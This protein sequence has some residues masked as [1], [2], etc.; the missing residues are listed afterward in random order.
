MK[1]TTLKFIESAMYKD[2][3]SAGVILKDAKTKA[4]VTKLAMV[5][6]DSVDISELLPAAVMAG[7]LAR[8]RKE[9]EPSKDELEALLAQLTEIPRQLRP[10]FL[11]EVK[12][13]ITTLPCG[14]GGGRQQKLTAQQ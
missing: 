6:P 4:I 10:F 11:K 5:L 12:T 9:K 14:T 1:P 8:L 2:F 13:V 7:A 3:E